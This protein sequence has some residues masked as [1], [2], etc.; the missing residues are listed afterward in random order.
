MPHSFIKIMR[1]VV[2]AG[3]VVLCGTIFSGAQETRAT[4]SGSIQDPNGA[5]IP[6]AKVTARNIRTGVVTTAT[7]A[8]DGN[9]TI[10]FLIPGNYIISADAQGF[11]TAQHTNVILHVGDKLEVDL[12]LPVGSVTEVVTVKD[13]PPLLETGTQAEEPRRS[14]TDLA[15]VYDVPRPIQHLTGPRPVE[16]KRGV[17]AEPAEI[18]QVGGV[19]APPPVFPQTD[20]PDLPLPK[21]PGARPST[22]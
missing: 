21:P 13:T 10:P 6:G 15:A 17:S 18:Q 22:A 19:M 20:T 11:K 4:V 3:L 9:Y 2:L 1:T 7:A 5:V 14:G 8:A 12:M 16:V